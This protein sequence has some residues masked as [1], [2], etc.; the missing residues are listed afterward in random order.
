MTKLQHLAGEPAFFS[1]EPEDI[2]LRSVKIGA[3]VSCSLQFLCQD[4]HHLFILTFCLGIW[5]SLRIS[6]NLWAVNRIYLIQSDSRSFLLHKI[7]DKLH[8]I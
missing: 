1:A 3:V 8:Y 6:I 2:L 5:N 7:N 4:L